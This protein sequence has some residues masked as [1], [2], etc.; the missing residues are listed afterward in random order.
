MQEARSKKQDSAGK[1]Q[2]ENLAS[3]LLPLASVFASIAVEKTAFCFDQAYDY[4]IPPAMQASI[5][6]GARVKIPFGHG[7]QLRLG[8]VLELHNRPPATP[9]VKMIAQLLDDSPLLP[10]G[11]AALIPWM[12]ERYFC[13]LYEAYCAMTPAGLRHSMHVLYSALP[14]E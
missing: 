14:A 6:P 11:L 3:C 2:E 5:A 7:K 10:D 1:V 8:V 12:K 13:T 9:Q 4:A